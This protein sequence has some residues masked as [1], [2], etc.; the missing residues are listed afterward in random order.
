MSFFNDYFKDF[1]FKKLKSHPALGF[2]NG[3]KGEADIDAQTAEI[4]LRT[5]RLKQKRVDKQRK[6]EIDAMKTYEDLT[7]A[8]TKLEKINL[9]E[10]LNFD[11]SQKYQ[12]DETEKKPP[13]DP[14]PKG[15]DLDDLMNEIFD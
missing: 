11:P 4:Q 12:A 5:E 7:K 2:I 6:K 13:Q 9:D 8:L 14:K 3:A 10:K 1:M 15:G